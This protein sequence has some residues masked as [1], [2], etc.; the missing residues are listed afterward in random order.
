MNQTRHKHFSQKRLEAETLWLE[1][2]K[3]PPSAHGPESAKST[4]QAAELSDAKKA[5]ASSLK[6]N[7]LPLEKI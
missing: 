5:T 7:G 2:L 1:F 4:S 6:V 3:E